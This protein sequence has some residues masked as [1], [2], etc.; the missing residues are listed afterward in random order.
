MIAPLDPKARLMIFICESTLSRTLALADDCHL[1]GR[2]L[3][4]GAG[5]LRC[6]RA[7]DRL[8]NGTACC[9]GTD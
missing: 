8:H 5:L 2:P 4:L 6:L 1:S 9:R 3:I 7:A